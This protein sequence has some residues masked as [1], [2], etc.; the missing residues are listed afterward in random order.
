MLTEL[1][2]VYNETRR[3]R[4][5]RRRRRRGRKRRRKRI[6]T[7]KRVRTQKLV[8][9]ME[10]ATNNKFPSYFIDKDVESWDHRLPIESGLITKLLRLRVKT[11]FNSC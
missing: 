6:Y 1:S 10:R 8:C 2:P 3:K 9:I 4:R 7:G 5:R 11:T